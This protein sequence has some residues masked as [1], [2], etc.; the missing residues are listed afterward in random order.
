MNNVLKK[1]TYTAVNSWYTSSQKTDT[2][3]T[4]MLKFL[5]ATQIWTCKSLRNANNSGPLSQRSDFLYPHFT[6]ESGNDMEKYFRTTIPESKNVTKRITCQDK[7]KSG[8]T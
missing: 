3:L 7:I 8:I 5:T 6:V 1:K 2:A 4:E